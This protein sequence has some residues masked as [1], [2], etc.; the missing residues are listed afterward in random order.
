MRAGPYYE[1]NSFRLEPSEGVLSAHGQ[2][3][4]LNK[5]EFAILV[6]LVEKRGQTV[7]KLELSKLIRG[8]KRGRKDDETVTRYVSRIKAK[9]GEPMRG[10]HP[11]YIQAVSGR[12][13]RFIYPDVATGGDGA[14]A[15]LPFKNIGVE[16]S[17]RDLGLAMAEFLSR[18]LINRKRFPVIPTSEVDALESKSHKDRPPV[19]F[20]VSGG[21]MVTGRRVVVFVYV[22]PTGG[23]LSLESPS[24]RETHPDVIE[25][26]ARIAECAA[27]EVTRIVATQQGGPMPTEHPSRR[28]AKTIHTSNAQAHKFY[29]EGWAFL[30]RRTPDALLEA[31]NYFKLAVRK[32]STFAEAHAGIADCNLLLA[33]FGSEVIPPRKAM[34][35]AKKAALRALEIDKNLAQA[36]ASLAAVMFLYE[37]DWIGSEKEFKEAIKNNPEYAT[38]RQFYSHNLA[39]LGETE[40]AL[41]QIQIAQ[42]L[43]HS[44]IIDATVSRIYFLGRKYPEAIEAAQYAIK[45]YRQFFL[46]YVHLGIVYKKLGRISEAV[47]L[48]I[49]A[50]ELSETPE[51]GNPA[52]LGELGH[53]LAVAKRTTEAKNLIRE[54][55]AMSKRQ[56]VAPINAAK[57]HM[58][59]GDLGR[60][61]ELL[62]QTFRDRSAWLLTLKRDPLYDDIR[63]LP[64]FQNLLRRIG[65][66]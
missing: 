40:K 58:G 17:E 63:E 39:L 45:R 25:S 7:H 65:V 28:A 14:I 21:V 23:E 13:Y 53:S 3:V 12:G 2:V 20:V 4:H 8:N 57:I 16:K 27:D 6:R 42:Q 51:W 52:I 55:K 5:S 56:Y 62:E 24:Y 60:T 35:R 19:K 30:N 31:L 61:F 29:E 34:P 46:G 64:P 1:F 15:V 38:A 22:K 41:A 50:R 33:I 43:R 37:R 18:S 47:D 66:P 9:L 54:L 48:L 44:P 26:L 49:E 11:T 59:L 36:H 10:K 32:D